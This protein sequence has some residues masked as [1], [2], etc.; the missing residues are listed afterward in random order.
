MRYGDW[1]SGSLPNLVTK[2]YN[3]TDVPIKKELQKQ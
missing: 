2:H 1:R 3:I